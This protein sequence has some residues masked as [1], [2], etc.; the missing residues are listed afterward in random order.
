[1]DC[2]NNCVIDIQGLVVSFDG[3]TVL[4]VD[5]VQVSSG[6]FISV[7]G[8]NGG[9]KTTFLKAILGLVSPI[10]GRI[11]VFGEDAYLGLTGIGYMPQFFEFDESFPITVFDLV[12]MGRISSKIFDFPSKS[13]KQFVLSILK[14]LEI[15]NLKDKKYGLLSGGQK[16]RAMI[17]RALVT[18]PKILLLD[19]PTSNVDVKSASSIMN[20]LKE[21]NKE[22]TIIM[23]SHDIGVVSKYVESVFCINKELVIH[24][25]SEFNGKAINE[26]Y[27]TDMIAVRHDH[28]CC[29]SG[30]TNERVI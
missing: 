2:D 26:L 19:E 20:I 4:S 18:K 8:P 23:V 9:G 6:D 21:L 25:T 7:V 5:N 30:H 13:D 27:S 28:I 3:Q 29:E 1:M 17:A 14:R 16:Q 24:P 11:K 10:S 12:L 22:I 15:E